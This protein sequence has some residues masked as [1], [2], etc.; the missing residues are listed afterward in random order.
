MSEHGE[1]D[2]GESATASAAEAPCISARMRRLAQLED[3]IFKASRL[4]LWGYC[5]LAAYIC[6]FVIRW[7]AGRWLVDKMGHPLFTDFVWIWVGGRF[8]LAGNAADVFNHASFAAAQASLTRRIPPGG[9]PFSY[10]VY[11]PTLLLVVAPF[12]ALPYVTAFLGWMLATLGV[13]LAAIYAILPCALAIVLALLPCG[14][15]MNV[16]VGHTGFLT[17]GLLGFS[18]VFMQRR[19]YLSGILLGLLIYKPQFGVFFPFALLITRQWRVI[20]GALASALLFAGSAALLLGANTWVLF[21]Q[22]LRE[23]NPATFLPS[24]KLE[25]MNQTVFGLAHWAGAG[26]A[27]AWSAHLAVA[28]PVAAL[29][30]AIWLRPGSYPLKAAAFSL[31]ALIATP[32]ML[33]YDLSALSV[34]GAFLVADALVSGFLAGERVA[35]LG[36]F[37]ALFGFALMPVGPLVMLVMLGLAMRRASYAASAR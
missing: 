19:P 9:V 17:A 18:L 6:A 26:V 25:A 3:R 8:A 32:Y 2:T 14:V 10:W 21:A 1:L 12:A 24:Y 7:L 15:L 31:A 36:C 20:A 4:S 34:P 35:L 11:P 30:C 27:A 22:S 23:H 29:A 33:I 5:F 28:I 37:L 13:Y 16:A